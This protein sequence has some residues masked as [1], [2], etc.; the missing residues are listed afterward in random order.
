MSDNIEVTLTLNDPQAMAVMAACRLYTQVGLG[1]LEYILDL[2]RDGIVPMQ[3]E[4]S[5]GR[6]V[7]AAE[8][9]VAT[10][11]Q[12]ND[13]KLI[14]GHHP[15]SSFGF[16]HPHVHASARHAWE[17]G[18]VVQNALLALE[19]P[20]IDSAVEVKLD[21]PQAYAVRDA[22]DFYSR[23][24]S[25]DFEEVVNLMRAGVIPEYRQA[26]DERTRVAYGKMEE[27]TSRLVAIKR[28]LGYP[29]TASLGIGHPHLDPAAN[30]TWE[31]KKS[32]EKALAMH[33]DP[34]PEFKG[35]NYD[36]NI[37]RYTRDPAPFATV[38]DLEPS[39][40]PTP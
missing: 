11:A 34:N 33:R 23:I 10:E 17:A 3:R 9:I 20:T 28:H 2:V 26:Q 19:E 1:K 27:A 18:D 25:G 6:A 8:A 24:C 39:A 21:G 29:D 31:V 38:R 4:A 36:G 12:L 30:R 16:R 22:C 32:L 5:E 40:A 13:I 35:V 37:V 15:N 7:A 14:L